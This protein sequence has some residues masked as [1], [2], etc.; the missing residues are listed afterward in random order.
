[1][2]HE[3]TTSITDFILGLEAFILV[4]FIIQGGH[5]FPSLPY[6]TATIIL[7]GIAAILGGF[8]HGLARRGLFAAI[9]PCLVLLMVAFILAVLTDVGGIELAQRA[10]WLVIVLVLAGILTAGR[11]PDPIQAAAVV[12]G[13]IMVPSL[14]AYGYLAYRHSLPGA[15]YIATAILAT[16]IA[17]VLLLRKVHLKFFYSFDPNGV[18]HLVQMVGVMLLYLGLTLRTE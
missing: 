13:L 1:M 7:L 14:I 17:I 18:Y 11:F 4:A 5:A 16:L 15:G 3:P 12:E 2:L 6:W 9:Y 8:A 10:R